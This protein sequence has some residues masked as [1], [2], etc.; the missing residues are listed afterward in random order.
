ML[1]RVCSVDV[2][3]YFFCIR[4][5][6]FISYLPTIFARRNSLVI[7]A[8]PGYCCKA[9]GGGGLSFCEPQQGI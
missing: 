6:Q 2:S 3:L 5:F 4:T 1:I 7:F 8:Q 9:V